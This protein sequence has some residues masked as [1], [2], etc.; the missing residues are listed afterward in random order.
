MRHEAKVEV[1]CFSKAPN[2]L[3]KSI[4]SSEREAGRRAVLVHDLY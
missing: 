4:A 1:R 2:N 3:V